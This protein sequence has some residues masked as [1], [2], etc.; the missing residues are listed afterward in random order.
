MPCGPRAR[1]TGY[2]AYKT[3][4]FAE[5]DVLLAALADAGFIRVEIAPVDTETEQS[6]AV[7][8]Q[9]WADG[10]ERSSGRRPR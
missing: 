7:V 1:L 3:L 4:T 10:R 2:V 8:R 5:R 6:S 9:H